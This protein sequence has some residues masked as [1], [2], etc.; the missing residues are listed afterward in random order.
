MIGIV[1]VGVSPAPG[2]ELA[3]QRPFDGPSPRNNASSR[4]FRKILASASA[5]QSQ[6]TLLHGKNTNLAEIAYLPHLASPVFLILFFGDWI[7]RNLKA[8]SALRKYLENHD[9]TCHEIHESNGR[10]NHDTNHTLTEKPN[11]DSNDA[12]TEDA[13][14]RNPTSSIGHVRGEL[15]HQKPVSARETNMDFNS[16]SSP[17]PVPHIETSSLGVT[18]SDSS[19]FRELLDGDDDDAFHMS[20]PEINHDNYQGGLDI[21]TPTLHGNTLRGESWR[22]ISIHYHRTL[23]P[24]SFAAATDISTASTALP[25]TGPHS[26]LVIPLSVDTHEVCSQLRVLDHVVSIWDPLSQQTPATGITHYFRSY[27]DRDTDDW[28]AIDERVPS[29]IAIPDSGVFVCLVTAYVAVDPCL[30]VFIWAYG[31]AT[32]IVW[33]PVED[34]MIEKTVSLCPGFFRH[35]RL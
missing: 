31:G 34:K 10:P 21:R 8:A 4:V 35:R 16:Y 17:A 23:L 14:K 3:S 6:S 28:R 11:P 1:I 30:I 25:P 2:V 19:D 27:V 7:F 12:G 32:C 15:G 24:T 20:T 26:R 33:H 5:Y 18:P 9:A 13:D 22:G 29:P